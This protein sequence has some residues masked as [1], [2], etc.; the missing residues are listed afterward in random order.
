MFDGVCSHRAWSTYAPSH[1][2]W[3]G[4]MVWTSET[5]Y[6]NDNSK[7]YF[8]VLLYHTWKLCVALLRV[9]WKLHMFEE[10]PGRIP[11]WIS[12]EPCRHR[13]HPEATRL[14]GASFK[15]DNFSKSY[16]KASLVPNHISMGWFQFLPG[17]RQISHSNV[18]GMFMFLV[19]ATLNVWPCPAS[20]CSLKVFI[21]DWIEDASQLHQR[22]TSRCFSSS[23]S[24]K[25]STFLLWMNI[26]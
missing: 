22:N 8:F 2:R 10:V 1:P 23:N 25:S 7:Q 26:S 9:Q 18:W 17:Q 24:Y 15:V 13:F 11:L 16:P 5:I 6:D 12:P 4:H 19:A 14:L 21:T 3:S 20:T